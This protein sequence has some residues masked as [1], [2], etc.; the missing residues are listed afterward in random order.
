MRRFLNSDKRRFWS[1]DNPLVLLLAGYI[2][3][4]NS[5]DNNVEVVIWWI[6]LAGL[7]CGIVDAG[8]GAHRRYVRSDPVGKGP[9]Q[10]KSRERQTPKD[11]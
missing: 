9:S 6:L 3:L 10:D 8:V 1:W 2:L 5:P 7:A 4:T 11:S